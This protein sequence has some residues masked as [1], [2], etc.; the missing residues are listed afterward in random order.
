MEKVIITGASGFLGSR[1][2]KYY[3]GKYEVISCTHE[4]LD[5]CSRSD[6]SDLI[7]SE[8]PD[9]LINCAA[10]SDTVYAASHPDEAYDIN[11][12]GVGILAGA[13]R[14]YGTKLVYMSSDQVYN[15]CTGSEPHMENE[16]LYPE[17]LYG[18][19]KLEMEKIVTAEDQE[20]VGLRLTW[21]YDSTGKGILLNILNAGITGRQTAFAD[22]EYRGVTYVHDLAARMEA[23]MKLPGG[24]YNCGSSTDLNTYELALET[25]GLTGVPSDLICCDRERYAG[26]IRNISMD[27]GK[28]ASRGV[29][30][31]TVM[32]GIERC[33]RT[34]EMKS[35]D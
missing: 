11:V 25:A 17:T 22:R 32:D 7:S 14:K 19:Q 1:L 5:L 33:F 29:S 16:E 23:V 27:M 9:Y 10:I 21:L 18:Q 4:M 13:C 24:I 34:F 35:T 31:P 28:L 12:R 26:H 30:F 15:G 2:I 8:K 6:V 3:Q 20:A